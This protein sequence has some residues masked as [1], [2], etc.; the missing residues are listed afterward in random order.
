MTHLTL[1][2]LNKLADAYL[3]HVRDMYIFVI[4]NCMVLYSHW[5][6]YLI[7]QFQSKR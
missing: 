5:N 3:N 7:G 1:Y 4:I 6:S 2:A